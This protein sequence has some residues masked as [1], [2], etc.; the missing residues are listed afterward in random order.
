LGSSEDIKRVF[1]IQEKKVSQE[2]NKLPENLT[3]LHLTSL[4][5]LAKPTSPSTL[6]KGSFFGCAA[7]SQLDL[8]FIK[9]T[10]AP[11]PLLGTVI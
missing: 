1:I 7:N 8:R 3:I 9:F 5:P 10:Q 6:P 4:Q 2:Y 11:E